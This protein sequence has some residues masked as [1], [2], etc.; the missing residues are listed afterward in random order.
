MDCELYYGLVLQMIN[1]VINIIRYLINTQFICLPK[2]QSIL[3]IG[4]AFQDGSPCKQQSLII[5]I[6]TTLLTGVGL[7]GG[8]VARG[9]PKGRR[10]SQ[11]HIMAGP[12]GQP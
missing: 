11:S 1:I 5:L 12:V 4:G 8:P 6:Y 2:S 3:N 10:A 7:P 9:Q